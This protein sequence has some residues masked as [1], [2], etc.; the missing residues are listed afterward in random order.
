[1]KIFL[2]PVL[3]VPGPSEF[4]NISDLFLLYS[5]EKNNHPTQNAILTRK[6]LY[7]STPLLLKAGLKL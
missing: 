7:V 4:R 1:M 6:P 5:E 2:K 3:P